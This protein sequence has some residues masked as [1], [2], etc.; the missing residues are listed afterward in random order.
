MDMCL[1][2][3]EH[4][5]AKR[6]YIRGVADIT[7]PIDDYDKIIKFKDGVEVKST[8]PKNPYNMGETDYT[9]FEELKTSI[10]QHFED[11]GDELVFADQYD[12]EHSAIN[13]HS[14]TDE[15]IIEMEKVIL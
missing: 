8:L 14:S 13:N 1:F 6:I 4:P 10:I 5:L 9:L 11:I 15:Y 3:I 7:P 12:S 2:T